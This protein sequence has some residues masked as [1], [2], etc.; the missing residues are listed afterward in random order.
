MLMWLLDE[1]MSMMVLE[2]VVASVVAVVC[3]SSWCA[4]YGSNGERMM[5]KGL[6]MSKREML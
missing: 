4:Y 5:G 2:F 1:I 3:G 6:T